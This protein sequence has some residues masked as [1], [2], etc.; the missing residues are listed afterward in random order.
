MTPGIISSNHE[1]TSQSRCKEEYHVYYIFYV[2]AEV[3]H[4]VDSCVG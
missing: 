1:M 3:Y 4:T 2:Y